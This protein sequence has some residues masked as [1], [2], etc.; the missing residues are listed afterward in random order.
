M[1]RGRVASGKPNQ[2]TRTIRIWDDV[3]QLVCQYCELKGG[4]PITQV[5]NRALRKYI[6]EEPTK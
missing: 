5:A 1:T 3:Y 2:V 4:L 6:T